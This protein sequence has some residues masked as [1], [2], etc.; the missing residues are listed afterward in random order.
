MDYQSVD[1]PRSNTFQTS[2]DFHSVSGLFRVPKHALLGVSI[3]T[4]ECM[5]G[6]GLPTN[7]R[8]RPGLFL[9]INKFLTLEPR[10][11]FLKI[12]AEYTLRSVSYSSDSLNA[13][14]GVLQLF[15]LK[16]VW[17]PERERIPVYHYFGVPIL[18]PLP[19]LKSSGSFFGGD[20]QSQPRKV[21]S[22]GFAHGL[23]WRLNSPSKHRAGFPSWSWTGWEGTVDNSYRQSY[24]I[25]HDS[26]SPFSDPKFQAET[27]SG[28]TIEW[29]AL[30]KI[31]QTNDHKALSKISPILV[32]EAYIFKAR[33]YYLAKGNDEQRKKFGCR[34][35]AKS[36]QKP[37]L[38]DWRENCGLGCFSPTIEIT[39]DLAKRLVE[40]EWPAIVLNIEP[41]RFMVVDCK[42]GVAERI[43]FLG[44]FYSVRDPDYPGKG[45]KLD[46]VKKKIRLGQLDLTL[47]S[48]Q[49]T[50]NYMGTSE[51]SLGNVMLSFGF[52]ICRTRK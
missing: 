19:V 16:P 30:M 42:H 4:T 31:I 13:V 52:A 44:E 17:Q 21:F 51:S 23:M 50:R 9:P 32:V 2:S 3:E 46:L 12:L 1:L 20:R 18:P 10:T 5:H 33:F 43:G 28:E 27:L 7:W 14:L 8:C 48:I 35:Y 47:S 29:D 11:E 45:A 37:E 24:H 15:Q 6:K 39:D 49:F 25:V 26:N 41:D 40:E 22:G 36:G 34:W 38:A